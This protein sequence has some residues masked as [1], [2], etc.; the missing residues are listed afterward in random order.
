MARVRLVEKESAPPEVANIYRKIEAN[1]A[2]ILNIYKTVANSPMV[3]LNFIRLGNAIMGRM[4]LPPRLRETVIL[5]VASLTGCE[6]ERAQHVPLALGTG[7]T[8][9]QLDAISNWQNSSELN[10]EERAVLK[11]VDEVTQDVR[12]ADQTFDGLRKFFDERSIVELTVT[13]GYYSMLARVLVA[14]QVDIDEFS[15]SSASDLTGKIS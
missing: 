14:L 1:G 7:M 10:E 13:I 6:Y 2:W 4:S 5:R 9:E 12:V 3:M 8:R 11:F 15:T